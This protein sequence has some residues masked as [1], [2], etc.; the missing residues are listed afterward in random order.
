MGKRGVRAGSGRGFG[1][2][3]GVLY[4]GRG[5]EDGGGVCDVPGALITNFSLLTPVSVFVSFAI[6]W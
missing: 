2:G 1:G 6:V 5:G 4:E 3:F